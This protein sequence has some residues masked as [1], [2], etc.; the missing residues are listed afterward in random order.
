M[1]VLVLNDF[2][3]DWTGSEIVALEVAEHF[4]ATTS[5][6]WCAEPVR[7]AL[8]DWRPLETI[9]LAEFDLVWAQQHA[10]FPLLERMAEGSRRPAI[11]WASLSPYDVMD[12][13]PA[14]ILGA[15]ADEVVCN[16][17][18]TAAARGAS[19]FFDNAA[20]DSFHFDRPERPLRNILFISN[21]Q[22]PEVLEAE[23]LLRARGYDTRF[24]GRGH[25]F[26]R[27]EPVD[28]A[29]ADCAVT[30]G[31]TVRYA[32]ASAL[33]VFVYDRFGGDGYLTPDNYAANEAHNFSGRPAC[34]KLSA[35]ELADAI[36]TGHRSR[37]PPAQPRLGDFLDGLAAR[38]APSPFARHPDLAGMAAMS[39][40][41]GSWLAQA[42]AWR[43]TAEEFRTGEASWRMTRA[44]VRQKL[45]KSR[46]LRWAR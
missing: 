26:K 14:T 12:D 1:R 20:P 40:A 28:L 15:Y 4:R 32:L 44:M 33:P 9:D 39:S 11:A 17:R 10:I 22:P 6:F 35:E 43:T 42:H 41:L 37:R 24:L 5:S 19:S 23:R 27:L 38:L 18:E 2:L 25:E 45:L 7:C 34:R 8:D 16:S 13:V 3:A 30:I 46:L 31:K 29:W 21:N 36:V